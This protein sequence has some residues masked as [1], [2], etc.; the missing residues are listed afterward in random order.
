MAT[1]SFWNVTDP[2]KPWGY[3]DKDSIILYPF[4]WNDWLA[5][6]IT[7]YAS[8]TATVEAPLEV[9]SS[10]HAA[11]VI[12]V[13]VGTV[14]AGVPVVGQKYALKVHIVCANGEEEDQT[15]YLKIRE[16]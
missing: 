13:K 10:T 16:K 1:G 6:S 9:K 5:D 4:D 12:T 7:T 15:V 8:H 2:L 3:H 11:G 14:L